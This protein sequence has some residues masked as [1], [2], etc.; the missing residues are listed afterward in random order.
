MKEFVLSWR[1]WISENVPDA[2]AHLGIING[3]NIGVTPAVA[4]YL[5]LYPNYGQP[6]GPALPPGY[7]DNPASGTASFTAGSAAAAGGK[8]FRIEVGSRG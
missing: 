3:V 7:S 2:N 8:L 6:G 4:P 5:A 1:C